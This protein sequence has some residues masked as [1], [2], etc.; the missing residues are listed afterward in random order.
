MSLV[1]VAV[2]GFATRF[3]RLVFERSL[4]EGSSLAFA[5]P[6]FRFEKLEQPLVLGFEL[7]DAPPQCETSVTEPSLHADKLANGE[8]RS[9]ASLPRIFPRARKRR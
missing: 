3:L 5:A 1:A 4:G 8:L 6:A 9:C 2:A 7:L